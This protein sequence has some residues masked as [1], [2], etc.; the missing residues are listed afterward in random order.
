MGIPLKIHKNLSGIELH[1]ARG[2][3]K[4]IQ[5]MTQNDSAILNN[6]FDPNGFRLIDIYEKNAGASGVSNTSLDFDLIDESQFIQ[7]DSTNGTDFINGVVQL[8][9]NGGDPTSN[10]AFNPNDISPYVILSNNN[11]SYAGT[12]YAGYTAARCFPIIS[13]GKWYWEITC[14]TNVATISGLILQ[15]TALPYSSSAYTQQDQTSMLCFY[16][17]TGEMMSP[18]RQTWMT[19]GWVAGK[20]KG[21]AF[22][23]DNG[24]LQLYTDGVA[25]GPLVTGIDMSTPWMVYSSIDNVN[26]DGSVYITTA[27]RGADVVYPVPTGFLPLDNANVYDS[28]LPYYV[29]TSDQNQVL[30]GDVDTLNSL[31]ITNSVPANT[32]LGCL[33][34]FDGRTTWKTITSGV[35]TTHP[36][37]TDKTN[38]APISEMEATLTNLDTTNIS[39]LDFAFLLSTTDSSVTPSVNQVTLNYD[40]IGIYEQA[41]DADYEVKIISATETS[42]SKLSTGT[43]ASIKINVKA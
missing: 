7:E 18:V 11:R 14:N 33:V 39:T 34:S 30:L 3:Q 29:T 16:F 9:D 38:W 23:A 42:I 21:F 6:Q 5:N 35:L 2:V 41:S 19:G 1:S 26:A 28:N 15:G 31:S 43:Q 20:V 13:S 37:L 27:T 24:T 22:D 36:G 4:T 17:N 40:E 32:A 25:D 8:H 10:Y 12:L